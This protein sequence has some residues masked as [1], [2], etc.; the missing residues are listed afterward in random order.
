MSLGG[1]ASVRGYKDQQLSGGSGGYWRN[2]LRW[3]RPVTL[4]WLRPF[5]AEYGTGLG[6]D[7]GVIRHDR[8]SSEVHGRVSSHSL[9]L[10]ARGRNVNASVTWAHSL[11]RPPVLTER[12]APVYVRLTF[13]L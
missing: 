1:S 4:E 12:E 11:E 13:F 5:F 6:Y 2:D 9:E 7:Q 10:F 8:Y 3:S